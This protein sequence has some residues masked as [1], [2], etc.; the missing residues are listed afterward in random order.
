M[1]EKEYRNPTPTVDIIIE[2]TG[3]IV[4]IE[5]GGTPGGWALPGGFHDEGETAEEAAVR[6]A[7]EETG[8]DIQLKELLYVYSDPRRDPRKHTISVVYIASADGTP[9]AG[10]DAKGAAVVDPANPPMPVAFDHTS[11]LADYLRFKRDGRR[12]LPLEML[13]RTRRL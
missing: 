4:M 10:D 1:S 3:G 8:L 6:E 5:R 12:P 11:I 7:K 9:L 13:G 2:V